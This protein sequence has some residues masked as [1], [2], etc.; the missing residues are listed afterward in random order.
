MN[1]DGRV[2]RSVANSAGGDVSGDTS[3]E[4]HQRDDIVWATYTGGSVRFGTLVAT[5]DDAGNLDMRYQHVAVDGT[6]K[7]GRCSSRVETLSDGRLR[8]HEQWQWTGGAEGRGESVIEE[9]SR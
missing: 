5:A 6:F 4:Y 2:F 1:Y 9:V 3:F 8:L 7:S